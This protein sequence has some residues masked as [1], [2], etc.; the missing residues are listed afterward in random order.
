MSPFQGKSY[1]LWLEK[2]CVKIESEISA[3]WVMSTDQT[4]WSAGD[5]ESKGPRNEPPA[6][7]K[8]VPL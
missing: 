2:M 4:A 6:H 8:Y 5:S 3:I 7:Q 1:D